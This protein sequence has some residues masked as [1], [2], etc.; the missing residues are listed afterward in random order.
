MGSPTERGRP[1]VKAAIA[2]LFLVVGMICIIWPKSGESVPNCTPPKPLPRTSVSLLAVGDTGKPVRFPV[3]LNPQRAV[4]RALTSEAMRIP[5]NSLL[6]LGDNFYYDGLEEE[7]AEQRIVD[8]VVA[9]YCPFVSLASDAT[10]SMRSAC[11]GAP[12]APTRIFAV[13]GNHDYGSPESPRLQREL[14]PRFVTNWK[15]PDGIASVVE[16]S[17]GVSLI[18]ADSE[19]ILGGVS[20]K[21]LI[22]ALRASLGPWRILVVHRPIRISPEQTYSRL[23]AA[24]IG[25]SGVPVQAILSGDDHNLQAWLEPGGNPSLHLISGSGASVK[26]IQGTG[27]AVA[28]ERLGFLR[29]DWS[30]LAEGLEPT[31]HVSMFSAARWPWESTKPTLLARLATSVAGRSRVEWA[32]SG[33]DEAGL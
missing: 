4:G 21:P 7:N 9:P 22:D 8:N 20:T 1:A 11:A 26:K 12:E 13:L 31:L 18:L 23:V 5:A 27:Q 15:V 25:E 29:L 14:I 17:P 3:W 6:L 28:F 30:P 2:L 10:R 24:A 32:C 16:L 33:N 19:R